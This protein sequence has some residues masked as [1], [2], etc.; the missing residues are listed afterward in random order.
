MEQPV[1]RLPTAQGGVVRSGGETLARHVGEVLRVVFPP[2]ASVGAGAALTTIQARLL[3]AGPHRVRGGGGGAS[4]LVA[5]TAGTDPTIDIHR[6][7]PAPA[8]PAVALASPAVAGLIEDGAHGWAQTF[9]SAAGETTPS[10]VTFLTVADKTTNGKALVGLAI[11]PTGTT[12]RKLYRTEAGL[13]ALKLVATIA[14]N[15]AR[16]YLDNV[17]DASLTTAAPTSNTA[18]ASIFT[19]PIA[20]TEST[21]DRELNDQPLAGVM[22]DANAPGEWEDCMY[23]LRA[24]TGAASGALTNL[25]GWLEIELLN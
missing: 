13:K 5:V 6:H 20:L 12:Q 9:V 22:A 8:A 24:K 25:S 11:G 18:S 21:S 10:P 15:T 7:L 4:D 1:L 3:A 17:A 2:V 19:A 16:T 14:N 23:S